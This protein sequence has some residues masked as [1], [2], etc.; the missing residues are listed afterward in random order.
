[1]LTLRVGLLLALLVGLS[2]SAPARAA[3]SLRVQVNQHGDFALIGNTFGQECA[4]GTPAPVV[5]TVGA[6]G[7]NTSD[8]SPDVFWRADS[9]ADG[10]AEANTGITLAQ[11]RSTAMLALPAGAQVTHAY[12]YW[13]A[14]LG[15]AGSD[16]TATLDRPGAGGFTTALT[17][18]QSLAN[19]S[20]YLSVADVTSIVQTNGVGAY[21]VSDVDMINFVNLTN[22]NV[23]GVWWMVVLYRLDSDP[24]RQLTLYDGLDGVANGTPQNSTLA[25]FSVPAGPIDAKLGVVAMDGDNTGTGDAFAFNSTTLSDALNPSNNFFNGTHSYLGTAVSQAG[26]LPQLDGTAQSMSGIDMDV[27]DISPYLT[28]GQTSAPINATTTSDVYFLTTFVTS[29]VT[30]QPKLE[31][32]GN[33]VAISSGDTTPDVADDTDFGSADVSGATM[34]HT[35]TISNTGTADLSIGGVSLSGA[36]AGDFSVTSSPAVTV[37]AGSSTTFTVTFD[38]SAVGLRAATVEIASNDSDAN[39]YAFAVQGTGTVTPTPTETPTDTPTSTPTDTPTSTPTSTPTDTPANTPTSTP[40]STPTA[41]T[42][43]PM[44]NTYLPLLIR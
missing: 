33:A 2:L 6:C 31:V 15:T 14:Y 16:S 11:A 38:P 28:A 4:A 17:A 13:S 29:I 18:S 32:Q 27:V 1:M 20:R 39:P 42:T 19:N 7:V 23:Y 3:P 24:L 35:F 5:G 37:T 10:Q 21:R 41:T 36:N 25:G 30:F 44:F 12:L 22:S 34:A 40:T 43:P 26:D 9:P 8:S